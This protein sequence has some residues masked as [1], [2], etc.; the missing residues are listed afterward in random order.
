MR[1]REQRRDPAHPDGRPPDLT[2]PDGFGTFY[3][4]HVDAI[5]GF[6]TRRVGD[7]HLAADLTADIFVAALEAAAGY[8][9]ERGTPLGWL[10]GIARHTVAGHR[11]GDDRERRALGRLQGRRLL[12]EED[13]L[14]LEE[15]I[16]AQRAV[17]DLAQRHARLSAPL[18]EVLDLVALDG[19]STAEAAQALGIAQ[20]TVRVRLHR[21]RRRLGAE[22]HDPRPVP[23][24][25]APML[26]VTP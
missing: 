18:R 17:R 5:L 14:A 2:T 23:T 19:L 4:Q 26:E 24:T 3:H 10:Y 1:P 11:R 6:V 22:R 16:D 21:A 15:R 25:A 12:A 7:P 9:P 20:A 8:R 13:I